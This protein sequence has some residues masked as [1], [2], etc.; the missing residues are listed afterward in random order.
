M[1]A[2]EKNKIKKP[3]SQIRLDVVW[4]IKYLQMHGLNLI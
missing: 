1:P 2:S 4:Q 3:N